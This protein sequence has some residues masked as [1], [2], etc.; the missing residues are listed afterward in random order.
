MFIYVLS[1]YFKLL[2]AFQ[3][4]VFDFV[5]EVFCWCGKG[6]SVSERK[7]GSKLA[8]E[9]S[10]EPAWTPC[11]IAWL[12]AEIKAKPPKVYSVTQHMEP[13]LFREKFT[14][15]PDFNRNN[16]GNKVNNFFFAIFV[17]ALFY[18]VMS[19]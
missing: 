14:D 1:N 2:I 10:K 6:S 18:L 3:V 13:I 4:M 19:L 17:I 8:T 9:L 12:D 16:I 5:T 11:G 15:W 7:M